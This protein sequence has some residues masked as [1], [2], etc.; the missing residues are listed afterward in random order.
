MKFCRKTICAFALASSTLLLVA[1]VFA[2]RYFWSTTQSIPVGLVI[3]PLGDVNYDGI[4]DV[5]DLFMVGKAY[6]SKAGDSNWNQD[7]DFNYDGVIDTIDVS[8]VDENYGL[9]IY[10]NKN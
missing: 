1:L 10:T 4:I 9:S 2:N 8:I 7:C 5:Y 6:G 3:L